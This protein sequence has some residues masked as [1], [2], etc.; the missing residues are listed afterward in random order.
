MK[1]KSLRSQTISTK[2]THEEQLRLEELATASGQGMSEWTRDVLLSQ[3]HPD[4][5]I[6]LA[7]VL[8]LRAI[9][10]NLAYAL[11]RSEPLSSERMRELTSRADADKVNRAR[12]RLGIQSSTQPGN[13]DSGS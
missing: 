1:R 11:S 2:V 4:R 6:L 8:A 13:I 3:L 10:L 5:E 12:E 7:E 9:L